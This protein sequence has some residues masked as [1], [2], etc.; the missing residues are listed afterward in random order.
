MNQNLLNE[1]WKRA[2]PSETDLPIDQD[3]E[4]LHVV[5]QGCRVDGIDC[6]VLRILIEGQPE[7]NYCRQS[8]N[9]MWQSVSDCDQCSNTKK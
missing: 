2:Q 9:G 5:H 1:L 8:P 3:P 7:W 6:M 4:D